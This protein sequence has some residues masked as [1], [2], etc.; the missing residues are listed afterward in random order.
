MSAIFKKA[1]IL[2]IAFDLCVGVASAAVLH[3]G[4]APTTAAGKMSAARLEQVVES[5]TGAANASC[6]S[7]PA[8]GWDYYCTSSDGSRTLYDV[9]AGRITQRADLPSHR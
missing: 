7:D 8:A 3:H 5:S 6:T 4:A 2:F 9:S 1:G